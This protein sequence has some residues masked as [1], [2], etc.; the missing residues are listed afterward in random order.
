[1]VG[2]SEPYPISPKALIWDWG[3]SGV[4]CSGK[5]M[6]GGDILFT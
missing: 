6:L 4:K 2:N 1:M 3:L 5:V